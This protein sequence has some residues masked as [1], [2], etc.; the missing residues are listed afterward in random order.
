MKLQSSYTEAVEV[1][2]AQLVDTFIANRCI[3]YDQYRELSRVVLADGT[4]DELER[5]QI[6]RLFDAIQM[7]MVKIVG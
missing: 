7:G 2:V 3:S 6:N 5:C 1:D 4:V